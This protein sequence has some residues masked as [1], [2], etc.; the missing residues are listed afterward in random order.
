MN[1]CPREGHL[2]SRR[3]DSLKEKYNTKF[4]KIYFYVIFRACK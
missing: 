4:Y 3:E 2:C 1:F